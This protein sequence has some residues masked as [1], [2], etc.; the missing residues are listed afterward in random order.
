M[1]TITKALLILNGV[2]LLF[3]VLWLLVG[4]GRGYGYYGGGAAT[5]V[6]GVLVMVLAVF[7]LSFLATVYVLLPRGANRQVENVA[8]EVLAR[9]VALQE[10]RFHGVL[11]SWSSWGLVVNGVLILFVGLYLLMNSERWDY[12]RSNATSVDMVALFFLSILNLAYMGLA[13][14]RFSSPVKVEQPQP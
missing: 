14:L 12:F 2:L 5:E 4:G 7:N 9:D 10:Q 11:R 8:H 13:Y 6:D 3:I 1:R